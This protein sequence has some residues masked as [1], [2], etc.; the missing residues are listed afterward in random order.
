[1]AALKRGASRQA[2]PDIEIE[3]AH[4]RDLNHLG[5]RARW[6]ST[7]KTQAPVHL[8]RHLLFEILAYRLQADQFGD[9]DAATARLLKQVGSKKDVESLA[10]DFDR[11]RVEIRPGTLLTREW[12][13]M[14]QR[15]MVLKG[16]FTW[17]GKTFDSLTKVAFAI[18]GTRWNGPRFFG[19][20]DK[21]LPEASQ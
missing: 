21:K 20:R 13:G 18:T 9:L 7:F 2:L 4:L 5:L 8:P 3:I 15:V 6:R 16:G 11:K 1:M 19:L 14:S 17:N 10:S 12:N